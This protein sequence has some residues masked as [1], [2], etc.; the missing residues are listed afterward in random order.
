MFR[1][2]LFIIGVL[3]N[4]FTKDEL[5]HINFLAIDRIEAIGKDQAEQEGTNDIY[6]K[7]YKMIESYCD[8]NRP[9]T[10]LDITVCLDCNNIIANPDK[11]VLDCYKEALE[12]LKSVE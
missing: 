5:A 9:Y 2:G 12:L 1:I 7:T 8:H 4:D 10:K 6:R 3:M 11:T